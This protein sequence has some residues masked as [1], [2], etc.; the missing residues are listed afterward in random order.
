MPH[1]GRHKEV[2]TRAG[3][4][5]FFEV[6]A[7]VDA[8]VAGNYVCGGL[9]LPMLVGRT[10]VIGLRGDGTEPDLAGADCGC[11]VDSG[12]ALQARGLRRRRLGD[13]CREL[14]WGL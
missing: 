4:Y 7:V 3:L 5:R 8:D 2:V 10:L 13:G 12:A 9:S 6:L 14:P 11:P 1:V